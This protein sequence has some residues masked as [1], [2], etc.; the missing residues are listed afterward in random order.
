LSLNRTFLST[1]PVTD[2]GDSQDDCPALKTNISALFSPKG[3]IRSRLIKEIN[4][5]QSTLNLAMYSFTSDSLRSAL[6]SARQRG[7]QI[8]I[9]ADA[10]QVNG[11]GGEIPYLDSHGFTVRQCNGGASSGDMHNKYMII[12]GRF[13]YTGSYNWSARAE[14]ASYE[15]ALFLNTSPVIADYLSDFNR[16]WKCKTS[17]ST[18]PNPDDPP[19]CNEDEIVVWVNTDSGIYHCPG[20]HYYGNTKEGKYMT[21]KAAISA[22]HRA[23]YFKPCK[24]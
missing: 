13:L 9:V 22:G 16:L 15:N 21:Q 6:V 17:G 11:V 14:S 1:I 2:I 23:A 10:G 18:D 3:G 4:Q 8:R 19:S 20:S 12:D 5:A 7:V 24:C